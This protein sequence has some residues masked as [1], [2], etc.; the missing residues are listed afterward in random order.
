MFLPR[1]KIILH[2]DTRR[3]LNT[4]IP[5][6]GVQIRQFWRIWQPEFDLW[7]LDACDTK[8][9]VQLSGIFNRANG[10]SES[11]RVFWSHTKALGFAAALN[12]AIWKLNG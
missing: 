7:P 4:G 1:A 5:M 10:Q 2:G 9:K 8:P 6:L 12:F 3:F 11:P